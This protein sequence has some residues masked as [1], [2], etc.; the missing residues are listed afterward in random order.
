MACNAGD[1][2]CRPHVLVYGLLK[3]FGGTYRYSKM[4]NVETETNAI[5]RT[6]AQLLFHRPLEMSG[7]LPETPESPASIKLASEHRIAGTVGLLD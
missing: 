1:W 7:K 2:K 5:D 3:S 6:V 4:P